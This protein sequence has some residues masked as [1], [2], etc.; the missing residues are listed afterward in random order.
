MKS[1][2]F[3][4][5]RATTLEQAIDLLARHRDE[6]RIL[7]G[8][9]TLLATL[10][11]RLSEPKLLIDITGLDLLRGIEVGDDTVVIGALTTHTEVSESAVIARHAPLLTEAAP[12]VAHRAIR[13]RGTWGGSVAYGDP[14]AEW[15]ACFL[16]SGGTV[17]AYGP[18]GESRIPI[19][20]FYTGLYTTSLPPYS[21][22]TSCE[23]P[24]VEENHCHAFDELAVRHGDYAIVGVAMT[25]NG[26]GDR[27]HD[28]RIALMGVAAAPVRALIAERELEGRA[29]STAN[30]ARCVAALR[31]E[32]APLPDLTN[33]SETKRHLAG[34]LTERCLR[35]VACATSRK[36]DA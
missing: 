14:S 25:A 6:A 24:R 12:H 10:N 8:G 19:D 5:V 23:L 15:P 13:N 1:P 29:P 31:E 11:M 27:L 18:D 30:I 33:S 32:I 16:A 35:K 21:I 9:Q 2:A 28:V 20:R 36:V 3:D 22:V 7:A 34:V 4:Y 26:E 17:V